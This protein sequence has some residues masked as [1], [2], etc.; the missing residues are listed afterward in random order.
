MSLYNKQ[1][2]LTLEAA[3][4][5]LDRALTVLLP[6]L[7]RMQWQRL[8]REG[9]VTVNGER[10]RAS[11]RIIGGEKLTATIP[12]VVEAEVTA[13]TIPLDIRYED[14]DLIVVNKPPSTWAVKMLVMPY[15]SE[16]TSMIKPIIAIAAR[17]QR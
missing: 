1:V 10:A 8:I 4:E 7:S 3:G 13:E 17:L 11:Y 15:R 6:D 16:N 2:E 9:M 14:R 5:R 12:D